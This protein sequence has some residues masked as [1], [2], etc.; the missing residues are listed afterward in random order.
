M[1]MTNLGQCGFLLE[2]AGV[3]IVTDPYLSDFVDRHH[4]GDPSWTRNY[5]PPCT[6]AELRPDLVL[7]SHAH[8]D[9]MDPLT[10]GAYRAAGGDC[11]IAA[12]APECGLL[13]HLHFSQI[14]EARAEQGFSQGKVRI[15]PVICAHT[16]PHVDALGRFREL[17]YLIEGEGLRVFFGGDASLYDGLVQ[18]VGKC[19]YAILPVNGRDDYRTFHNIIG[20][21]TP[22]EACALA[23]AWNAVLIPAHYDLYDGNA[24]PLQSVQQAAEAAGVKLFV[25][26]LGMPEEMGMKN[27]A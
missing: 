21:T 26:R 15:T 23:A 17:S 11:P 25:P 3:R 10:L 9:H 20:N 19:D 27:E 12:P 4:A 6:L 24:C 14:I 8:D 2:I 5:A 7:I 18:R 16:E 13:K 1:R 22:E